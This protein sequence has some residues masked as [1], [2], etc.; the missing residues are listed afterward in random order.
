MPPS[1]HRTGY[2]SLAHFTSTAFGGRGGSIF[3]RK[4]E[5]RLQTGGS[6]WLVKRDDGST[7][8]LLSQRSWL[9]ASQKEEGLRREAL[10]IAC[11][12]D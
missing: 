3:F 9:H 2:V 12:L 8:L 11:E 1:I 10:K 4:K 6:P 5:G 7:A